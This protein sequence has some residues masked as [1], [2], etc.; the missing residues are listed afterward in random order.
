MAGISE[1]RI[2]EL[3]RAGIAE[4]IKVDEKEIDINLPISKLD[5]DSISVIELCAKLERILDR[6]VRPYMAWDYPTIAKMAAFLV[7]EA[8]N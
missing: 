8:S 1:A 2:I 7:S 4:E 6:P 3:I 5:M